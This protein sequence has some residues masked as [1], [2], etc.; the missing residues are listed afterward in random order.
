MPF[1]SARPNQ[2]P[3]VFTTILAVV[4]GIVFGPAA[5]AGE[6]TPAKDSAE[7]L[8]QL[9][10]KLGS[11]KVGERRAAARALDRLGP[12]ALPA[13]RLAARSDDPEVSRR[14]RALI[15]SITK[16]VERDR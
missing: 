6:K 11:Q 9:I 13:L 12:A 10:A 14:A 16:R 2:F 5:G 1:L 7:R 4:L 8:L 15:K 3:F